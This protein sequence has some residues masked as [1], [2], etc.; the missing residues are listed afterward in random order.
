MKL[1]EIGFYTLSDERARNGSATSPME[2]CELILTTRCAFKCEYCRGLPKYSG[3]IS[4][5]DAYSTLKL[6]C[7]DNLK[8]VRFSGGEPT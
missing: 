4:V 3:D 8:H 5:E 2:R 6:W 7:D 1:E